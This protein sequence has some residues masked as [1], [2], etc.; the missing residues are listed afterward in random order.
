MCPSGSTGATIEATTQH[1]TIALLLPTL[2][3]LPRPRGDHP[4]IDRT[5][6]TTSSSS[7]G[8]STD[9][10]DQYAMAMA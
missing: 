8:G 4:F 3:E 1:R 5:W 6:S 9:G 7:D 2:N 10:I